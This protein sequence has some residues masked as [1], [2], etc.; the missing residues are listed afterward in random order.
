LKKLLFIT[1][2]FAGLMAKGQQTPQY[3]Q[4]MLNYFAINP[5]MAG[6]KKCI[7]VK[8]GYRAQWVGFDGN[9]RTAFATI[10]SRIKFKKS[11]SPYSHHGFGAKVEDDHTGLTGTTKLYLA[12]AYHFAAFRDFKASFGIYGG[13]Q[14]FKFK[15][16]ESNALQGPDPAINSVNSKIIWP[17]FTPGFFLYN[18]TMYFGLD[19]RQMLLNKIKGYGTDGKNRFKHHFEFLAGA[20]IKVDNK[21]S[22]RPSVMLKFTPLSVPSFDLNLLMNYDDRFQFGLSYRNT[23]ALAAMFK[24]NFL[25]HFTLGYSFDLTTSKMRM[26]SSN[27]HEIVLGLYTCNVRGGD[28]FSCPVFD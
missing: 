17:D 23:D 7:D 15:V 4:Y 1:L 2:L 9:P 14:Q 25:E 12:Y 22:Y 21:I 26:G 18:E 19:M 20:D 8:L 16:G 24:V 3:T 28:N 13:I 6:M 5:A 27:S 10:S 11:K